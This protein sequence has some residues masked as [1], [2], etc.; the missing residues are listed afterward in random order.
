MG[1]TTHEGVPRGS[2]HKQRD[3]G[4]NRGRKKGSVADQKDN[5]VA[6]RGSEFNGGLWGIRRQLEVSGLHQ[7][8][9][10]GVLT[11]PGHWKA[12]KAVRWQMRLVF[13]ETG[14]QAEGS[15]EQ[16]GKWSGSKRTQ[17]TEI[18]SECTDR[19]IQGSA[20]HCEASTGSAKG[21]GGKRG[22]PKR[23]RRQFAVF[24]HFRAVWCKSRA[25][26]RNSFGQPQ[27]TILLKCSDCRKS[28]DNKS[29]S[30]TQN[31]FAVSYPILFSTQ[32][33]TPDIQGYIYKQKPTMKPAPNRF[34]RGLKTS[35]S[36]QL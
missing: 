27:L 23:T 26:V 25:Q 1:V 4:C 3:L 34:T 33:P 19:R 22:S 6:L 29:F 24:T 20:M 11:E 17:V 9:N 7:K 18:T 16:K 21:K 35:I 14:R 5:E 2:E 12:L 8:A 13:K 30:V 15:G 36:Q 31:C 10:Q 28:Q 32:Q